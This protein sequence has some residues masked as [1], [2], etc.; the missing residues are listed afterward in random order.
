MWRVAVLATLVLLA[1]C[2]TGL[3]YDPVFIAVGD[4]QES[5]EQCPVGSTCV[6][7]PI[8][9]LGSAAGK[10]GRCAIHDRPGDAATM[11]PLTEDMVEVP[12]DVPPTDDDVVAFTWQATLPG[13]VDL[14]SAWALCDRMIEG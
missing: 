1:G 2:S 10:A 3:F 4:V 13:D 9:G 5:S 12:E 11:Q 8:E 7:V 14:G 6:G